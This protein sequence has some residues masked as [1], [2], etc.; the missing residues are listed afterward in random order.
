[1]PSYSDAI[2]A[3]TSFF[4]TA[5][6]GAT[7]IIWGEDDNRSIPDNATWVRFNIRHA[8]GSQVTMGAPD[9]NRFEQIGTVTIQIFQPE[10]QHG[11][12]AQAKANTA[13][14]LYQGAN[15]G[16][17]HYYNARVREVGNDGNGWYQ[18]NVLTDFRYEQI[19]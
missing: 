8:I 14:D 7:T 13:L 17:I 10:G 18:I 6:A 9:A 12:D 19:T 11:L 16:G 5:W 3:M 1:M 4:N 15:I 2:T